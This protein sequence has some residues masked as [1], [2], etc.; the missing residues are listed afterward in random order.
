MT[1][2]DFRSSMVVLS[3]MGLVPPL[4]T[5]SEPVIFKFHKLT[6][7][8]LV[9]IYTDFQKHKNLQKLICPNHDNCFG[10][11]MDLI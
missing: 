2:R 8:K 9:H 3:V 7:H 5:E 11:T 10:F 4:I 1:Q 6:F